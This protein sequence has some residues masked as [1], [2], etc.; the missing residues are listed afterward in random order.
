LIPYS[1]PKLPEF[2][3]YPRPNCLKTIPFTAAHTYLPV[4]YIWEYPPPGLKL[5]LQNV[6]RNYKMLAKNYD[7]KSIRKLGALEQLKAYGDVLLFA[8]F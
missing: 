1:R 6:G 4:G 5:A 7:A 2:Y 8:Y 3:T